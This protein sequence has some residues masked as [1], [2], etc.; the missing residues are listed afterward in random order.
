MLKQF[1]GQKS[2]FKT[3]F[4]FIDHMAGDL[5][6]HLKL[7]ADILVLKQ[8]ASLLNVSICI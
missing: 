2:L 8:C 7:G 5:C 4:S 6:W 3:G 1:E